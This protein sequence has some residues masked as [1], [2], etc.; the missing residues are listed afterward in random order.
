[1]YNK[2]RVSVSVWTMILIRTLGKFLN[3]LA[4]LSYQNEISLWIEYNFNKKTHLEDKDLES[5]LVAI[6]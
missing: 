3:P 4:R 5:F 2:L 6:R 1:M